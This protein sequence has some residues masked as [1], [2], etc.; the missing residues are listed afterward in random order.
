MS[1]S[2]ADTSLN[3]VSTSET[4]SESNPNGQDVVTN[5]GSSWLD[6]LLA[7][8]PPDDG[9]YIDHAL[10]FD[11]TE[12][13]AK[14]IRGIEGFTSDLNKAIVL[15]LIGVVE[16]YKENMSKDHDESENPESEENQL[17]PGDLEE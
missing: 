4:T 7:D 15:I 11:Q 10:N 1:D 16:K 6:K 2:I 8:A 3:D 9:G 13:T 5:E 17:V 12:S 14:I